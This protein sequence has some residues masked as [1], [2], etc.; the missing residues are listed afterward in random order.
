M[1]MFYPLLL[2]SCTVDLLPLEEVIPG[3]VPTDLYRSDVDGFG[4]QVVVSE[5]GFWAASDEAGLVFSNDLVALDMG[6][7]NQGH[8]LWTDEGKLFVGVAGRGVFDS[9][10]VLLSSVTDARQFAGDG[11]S[12]VA[13]AEG[14]VVAND[15]RV[16]NMSD[17]RKVAV[18]GDRIAVLSCESSEC[19]IYLLGDEIVYVG[20]GDPAG[21]IGFWKGELWWGLPNTGSEGAAGK[22]VSELGNV[23]EGLEGD[24]LGR[25]FGGGFTS[26]SLNWRIQPRRMR[27]V[28]L[29]GKRV[30]AL[31]RTTGSAP[32]S[33]HGDGDRLLV[34]LPG[35]VEKGG[36]VVVVGDLQLP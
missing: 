10:G 15:G 27:V 19:R 26:G 22:V 28:G 35:W 34:G 25:T 18:D 7:K 17:P 14:R 8:F 24:H 36:A 20:E 33:L 4:A 5:S 23:V 30:F 31:D 29:E 2:V 12:W 21:G 13:A 6:F 32:A 16:W 9:T 1:F 3:D 11:G